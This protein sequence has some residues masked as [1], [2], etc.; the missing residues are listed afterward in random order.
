MI[1]ALGLVLF[2]ALPLAV[3][4]WLAFAWYLEHRRDRIPILLY[5]RL[6]R[7][8]DAQAGRVRDDERIWVSYEEVFA[9]QMDRLHK[10]GWTT[11]DLDDYV[12]IRSG[13]MPLPAKPVIVTFDDGYESNYTL[14]FPALRRN[15][16]KATVYVA[17]EPDAHTRSQV[18]GID[19]FLSAEQMREMAQHGVAIQSHSLTHPILTELPPDGVRFELEESKR[20]LEEITGRP[21]RHLAIPRAGYSRAIRRQAQESGYATVCCNNKGSASGLSDP[22]ALPR[23][24]VDRETDADDLVRALGPRTGFLLR[25][26]GNVKR[27]P[28]RLGGARFARN[29]RDLLYRGPLERLFTTRNLKRGVVLAGACYV[30]AG[31]LFAWRL[32]AP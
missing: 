16:Q 5:H 24:V 11:L 10:E 31:L 7:R 25:V 12:R 17:L 28:E 23:I 6:I 27:I 26:V 8:E 19:G 20:R 18:E 2:V 15:G 22:L 21:V 14:A 13:E 1:D 30:G 9:E 32:L 4:A 3:A 29:V